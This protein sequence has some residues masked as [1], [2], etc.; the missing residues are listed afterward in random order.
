MNYQ[1]SG[2]MKT[3]FTQDD[4]RFLYLVSMDILKEMMPTLQLED[5]TKPEA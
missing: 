4:I 3:S 5:N 2:T 1:C